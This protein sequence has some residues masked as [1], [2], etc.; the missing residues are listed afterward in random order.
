MALVFSAIEAALQAWLVTATGIPS[1]QVL[2]ELKKVPQLGMPYITFTVPEPRRVGGIDELRVTD[3]PGSP[4]PVGAEVTTTVYGNREM[5]ASIRAFTQVATGDGTA[6]ELLS[7]AQTSLALPN[8]RALLSAA[9]LAFIDIETLLD[10][11]S[12]SGPVGQ[13]RAVMDVRFRCVDTATQTDTFIETV[14]TTPTWS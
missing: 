14:Q 11:S 5:V 3:T 2:P 1:G 8:A 4:P 13:G 9:G 7:R 6:K 12:R 10:L